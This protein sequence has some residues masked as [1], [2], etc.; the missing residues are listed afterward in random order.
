MVVVGQRRAAFD[1]LQ[2]VRAKRRAADIAVRDIRA[3]QFPALTFE[4]FA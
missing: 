1:G 4:L 3:E 2:L